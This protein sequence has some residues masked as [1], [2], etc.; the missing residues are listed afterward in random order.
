MNGG[1]PFSF[2]MDEKGITD[3]AHG[4]YTEV[5]GGGRI[6]AL[7]EV[8]ASVQFLGTDTGVRMSGERMGKSA[9]DK[10]DR[11]RIY[12]SSLLTDWW[13]KDSEIF[14]VETMQWLVANKKK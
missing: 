9:V 4:A 7:G 13:G 12:M 10:V 5:E 11:T 6:I 8:M 14:L 2:I 3:L 1:T